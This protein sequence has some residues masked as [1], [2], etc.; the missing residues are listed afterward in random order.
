MLHGLEKSG[1]LVR[2]ERPVG[3]KVRKYYRATPLDEQTLGELRAKVEELVAKVLRDEGPG[4][5]T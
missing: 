2:A 4:T 3:G 5:L 1:Y